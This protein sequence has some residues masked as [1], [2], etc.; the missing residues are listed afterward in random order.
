MSKILNNIPLNS[1]QEK[2]SSKEVRD[3]AKI[4]NFEQYIKGMEQEIEK[5]KETW[6]RKLS[7][8]EIKQ[9]EKTLKNESKL[10]SYDPLLAYIKSENEKDRGEVP[11]YLTVAEVALITGLSPQMV[12]RHCADG[13]F[14]AFQPSGTNGIW[15]IK[16]SNFKDY[17]GI[18]WEEFK[19]K[20]NKLFSQS[21]ELAN[22]SIKLQDEDLKENSENITKTTNLTL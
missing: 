2:I 5:L 22:D 10:P 20:R 15:K 18:T 16:A 14:E 1:E 4:R 19:K 9:V 6:A 17:K 21:K 7:I 3:Y 11:E 12:R 13:K 8:E